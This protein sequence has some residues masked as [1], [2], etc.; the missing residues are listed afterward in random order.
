MN[1][2]ERD[3]Y[4]EIKLLLQSN[5]Q[6]IQR[7]HT[8]RQI[9]EW[10]FSK[11][12]ATED[13]MFPDLYSKIVFVCN[14]KNL[15]SSEKA[16]IHALRKHIHQIGLKEMTP[17]ESTFLQDI[18]RLTLTIHILTR[19]SIPTE[20][21][22][23]ISKISLA[24]ADTASSFHSD[25]KIPVIRYIVKEVNDSGI[26]GH[27]EQLDSSVFQILKK[28]DK[29]LFA[30][31]FREIKEGCILNLVNCIVRE[32]TIYAELLILEPD[33]LLDISSIAECIKSYGKHP[34]FFFQNQLT[35]KSNS[36][37]IL[38]GNIANHFLDLFVNA[39]PAETVSYEDAMK[40][41]FK[42]YPIP[43][44][45][46][47][48][49]DDMEKRSHFFKETKN[50]FI[51]LQYVVNELFP[52]QNI[53][54]E[55]AVLE[56]SF[57]CPQLGIQGRLDFLA[58]QEKETIVIELKSGKAPFPETQTELVAVNH[59]AQ[60]FLYQIVIQKVLGIPFKNMHSYL[61]YS[62]YADP[63]ANLR[64][65]V[66][67]LDGIK[68]IIDLRNQI[69][70]IKKEIALKE[71]Y[72]QEILSQF[73]P[74]N[75]FKITAQ[76]QTFLNRFIIPQLYHFLDPLKQS[77]PLEKA[78]FHRFYQFI[79]KEHYLAKTGNIDYENTWGYSSLWLNNLEE[80][81][82][83]GN[84]LLDL[85]IIQNHSDNEIPTV[86]LKLNDSKN[87][88]LPNFRK[89]DIV[90]L[91]SYRSPQDNVT[92]QRVFR[93]S[94]IDLDANSITIRLRNRQNNPRF[95]SKKSSYAIEHDFLDSSFSS[96]YRGLYSF[97]QANSDRKDLI[98]NQKE[99]SVNPDV[100]LNTDIRDTDIKE[101]IKSCISCEDYYLLVGPP[102]TGKTSIALQKM[103]E[104]FY[105]KNESN[106]L[107]MA[108]TNRAVDEICE[109]ISQINTNLN[110]IRIGSEFST[111]P[112]FHNNLLQRVIEPCTRREEVKETIQKCRIIV[113]T[114]ASISGR[115]EIFGMKKFDVAIIDEASQ[116]LEPQILGILSAKFISGEN[117]VKKF[118]LI[119]DQK[120]LP[121]IVLQ[122]KQSCSIKQEDMIT[123]GITD[124]GTSFFERLLHFLIKNKYQ[125]HWGMLKKQGRM[126]PK[127]SAF[128]NHYFYNDQLEIVPIQHQ[129]ENKIWDK[130]DKNNLLQCKIAKNRLLFLPSKKTEQDLS[131]K[132]NS[133]EVDLIL[134][135]TRNIWNLYQMNQHQFDAS[136][137]LGIIT[138]YRSQIAKIKRALELLN[139]PDMTSITVDTVERNQ[140]SQ[141]DIIIYSFCINH[142]SQ[143][144]LLQN[145]LIEDDTLIDR[146]LNVALTRARKQ[147][148]ILGNPFYLSQ[149]SIFNNLIHHIKENGA[150]IEN[151]DTRELT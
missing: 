11:E 99:L 111:D 45:S 117:A 5:L 133:N 62:K 31:T 124:C 134:L 122:N 138:P 52:R 24:K 95:L 49:L 2:A 46:N 1:N 42:L 98:L 48:D 149:N 36:T 38:I 23:F 21:Q 84:I 57:I 73:K 39:Q 135:L 56:P 116:I 74:E 128:T 143:L 87:E 6:L 132:V 126:H 130:F 61:L 118:I 123:A 53:Q 100:R 85:K 113:G 22:S 16:Q 75:L 60:L 65:V 147:L 41:I 67:Y 10:L 34:Y 145:T 28:G 14:K 146:K 55:K 71:G 86:V 107:L 9:L 30:A 51:H 125:N 94:I 13:L 139:I 151:Q 82:Q 35:P 121:A 15:S 78:Y 68:E 37:P 26:F 8:I 105:S 3:F 127:I 89:G 148:F 54:R 136:K 43:L 63:K 32:H 150:F 59:R 90:N 115:F 25:S 131:F 18:K 137:S 20:I 103:V 102:G 66:P 44:S 72:F 119:G 142:E 77:T 114:V 112:K 96:M 141:R 109:S 33:Y 27:A 101:I 12:T 83:S 70:H 79:T 19:K 120:Q 29:D 17:D 4:A 110:F 69:V 106:I 97:L 108:Y 47:P 50:Q 129:T 140:G 80:K 144:D 81:L 88:F 104:E 7:Y 76:N 64:M 93:A 92:N 58:L 91:Y 40:E